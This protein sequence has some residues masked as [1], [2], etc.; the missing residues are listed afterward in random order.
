MCDECVKKTKE[1]IDAIQK[2]DETLYNFK[3]AILYRHHKA[4]EREVALANCKDKV[5]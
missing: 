1:L 4:E 3:K 5:K 2:E